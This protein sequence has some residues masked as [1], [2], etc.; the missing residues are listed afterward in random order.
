[1]RVIFPLSVRGYREGRVG[2][3]YRVKVIA[4]VYINRGINTAS[5]NRRVA[6]DGVALVL[7]DALARLKLAALSGIIG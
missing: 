4:C 2:G 6:D 5:G 1:M 7:G 3:I